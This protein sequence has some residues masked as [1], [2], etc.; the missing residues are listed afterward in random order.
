MSGLLYARSLVSFAFFAGV[1]G[2]LL[3][4]LVAAL[5]WRMGFSAEAA[6]A[7]GALA[8][9]YF[10]V[11]RAILGPSPDMMLGAAWFLGAIYFLVE[12]ARAEE[13]KE[14]PLALA[15]ITFLMGCG[16]KNIIALQTPGFG[17]LA[18]WLLGREMWT[19]RRLCAVAAGALLGLCSSSVLW[20]YTSNY[21]A[22]H[23][24]KGPWLLGQNMARDLSP[25]AVWTR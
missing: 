13:R 16:S 5:A 3:I 23:D 9:A 22:F 19:W 15:T 12:A 17:L 18:L 21:L 25:V 7:A 20:N 4:W 11:S 24:V 10:P 2:L 8:P 6:L 1:G 14:V